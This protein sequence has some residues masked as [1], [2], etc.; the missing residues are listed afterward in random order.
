MFILIKYRSA[1]A[2]TLP[3]SQFWHSTPQLLGCLASSVFLS[4][5]MYL[6]PTISMLIPPIPQ[7][8]VQLPPGVVPAV[9]PVRV[10]HLHRGDESGRFPGRRMSSRLPPVWQRHPLPHHPQESE[11]L[12]AGGITFTFTFFL[13]FHFHCRWSPQCPPRGRRGWLA[14]RSRSRR[15]PTGS[16][17]RRTTWRWT[18]GCR[19]TS[20]TTWERSR[21]RVSLSLSRPSR[22]PVPAGTCSTGS[23]GDFAIR[24]EC[25]VLTCVP[26]NHNLNFSDFLCT[27]ISAV[28]LNPLKTSISSIISSL[29]VISSLC[30]DHCSEIAASL[31]RHHTN[32]SSKTNNLCS[33]SIF[34]QVL[35]ENFRIKG[36]LLYWQYELQIFDEMRSQGALLWRSNKLRL[37]LQRPSRFP[38]LQSQKLMTALWL[39]E[40]LELWQIFSPLI[41]NNFFRKLIFD[42]L[43]DEVYCQSSPKK[44]ESSPWWE[45]EYTYVGTKQL[46]IFFSSMYQVCERHTCDTSR[47]LSHSLSP[48][49]SSLRLTKVFKEAISEILSNPAVVSH[50]ITTQYTPNIPQIYHINA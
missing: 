9:L 39:P 19:S 46:M 10:L 42:L 50:N 22:S 15:L 38:D 31:C 33:F 4:G 2:W 32:W 7:V 30:T 34:F 20:P 5:L 48:T 36:I 13:H 47:P 21:T 3:Q 1:T 11:V 6:C 23:A 18:S 16:T 35:S 12:R 44:P 49:C 24:F 43:A 17:A 28:S 26:R 45:T 8:S 37:A 25:C 29:W 27:V 40:N 41:S 14:S